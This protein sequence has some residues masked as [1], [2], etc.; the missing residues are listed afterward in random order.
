[1]SI[2]SIISFFVMY[3]MVRSE[4][5]NG[6]GAG[7]LALV[8]LPVFLYFA[9]YKSRLIQMFICLVILTLVL[10]SMKRGDILACI[11][12]ILVYYI[13]SDR[14]SISNSL[15]RLMSL[16]IIV[17]V[18][19]FF[20]QYLLATS[21]VFA[22]RVQQTLDGDTSGRDEIYTSLI[23]HFRDAPLH[24]KLFGGGFDATVQI[25]GARAH[26]DILEILS[27]EGILGLLIYIS[28]YIA[29]FVEMIKSNSYEKA[30]LAM[31]LVI[32]F[33][34]MFVSMFIFSQS[35]IILVVLA[36]YIL[37]KINEKRYEC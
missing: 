17:I 4:S 33:V 13:I 6:Y 9:R 27:C 28:A 10:V 11:M 25:A 19:Y 24:A 23:N 29:L 32:W 12:S 34:K 5:E 18:G 31:I 7:Y 8:T 16:A 22:F 36:G 14:K 2:V 37:N 20:F 1:M 21:D 35:T 3:A 15:K 30:I 26:S